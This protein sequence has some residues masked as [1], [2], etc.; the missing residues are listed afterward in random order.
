MKKLSSTEWTIYSTDL[1]VYAG[2]QVRL[3][4]HYTSTDSFLAQIDDFTV[5]PED[6]HGETVDYGNIDRF[7]I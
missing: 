1:S 3:A 4:V 5:G 2:E 6:G 7:D